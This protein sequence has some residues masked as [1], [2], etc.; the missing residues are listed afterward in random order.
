MKSLN[1]WRIKSGV[2]LDHQLANQNEQLFGDRK[3]KWHELKSMLM[4]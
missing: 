3:P 4:E 1:E 2:S